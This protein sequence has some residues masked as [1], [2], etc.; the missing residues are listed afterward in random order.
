[1]SDAAFMVFIIVLSFYSHRKLKVTNRAT[2]NGKC[3]LFDWVLK[4]LRWKNLDEENFTNFSLESKVT[5]AQ[6]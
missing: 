6:C 2:Q 3:I 5:N 1:M 4:L